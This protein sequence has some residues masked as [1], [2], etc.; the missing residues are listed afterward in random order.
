MIYP[1]GSGLKVEG[2]ATAGAAHA[3]RLA[4][5]LGCDAVK[6]SWPSDKG[7][8]AEMV[9][10]APIPVLIAGGEAEGDF[11]QVL[12]IVTDSISQG[13]AGV[14]MGRQ[15]FGNNNPGNCIRALKMLIHDGASF[16][17]ACEVL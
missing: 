9:N 6:T 3:V 2:D 17:Q 7:A 8:F 14:C 4:W 11:R 10:A 12:R 15:V 1:R 16:E 13:G 5:E